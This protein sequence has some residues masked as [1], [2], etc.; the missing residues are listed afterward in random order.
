MR[1]SVVAFADLGINVIVDDLMIEREFF[2][3]YAT[4]FTKYEFL[5]VAVRCPLK[6]VE[7]R[8]NLRPGRFPGTATWHFERVHEN[9]IYDLQ[10][11]TSI[12]SPRDCAERILKAFANKKGTEIIS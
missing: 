9:M 11:D 5:C 10:V 4:L 3:D 7:Q 12:N 1:R 2:E 6:E 8:E